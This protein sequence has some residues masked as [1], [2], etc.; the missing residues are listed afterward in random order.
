M[1]D[2]SDKKCFNFFCRLAHSDIHYI[3]YDKFRKFTMLGIICYAC[4]HSIATLKDV[5]S[6]MLSDFGEKFRF[7]CCFRLCHTFF[8]ESRIC[9]NEGL[10]NRSFLERGLQRKNENEVE[11]I[12]LICRKDHKTPEKLEKNVAIAC[13]KTATMLN[14]HCLLN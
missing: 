8:L 12:L 1:R 5:C 10:E 14:L 9:C 6:V 7:E 11:Q 2:F 4:G 13:N 3:N